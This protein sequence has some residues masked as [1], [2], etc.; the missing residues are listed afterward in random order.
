MAFDKDQFCA[1]AHRRR[2]RE[3]I[4]NVT[5]LVPRGNYHRD[6][7]TAGSESWT[8]SGDDEIGQSE[9]FE[10]PKFGQKTVAQIRYKQ[11]RQ[12]PKDVLRLLNHLAVRKIEKTDDVLDCQP[13]LI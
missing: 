10:R 4:R 5:C 8:R 9:V 3:D 1:F 7:G 12:K 6:R 13:V 11:G 2:A